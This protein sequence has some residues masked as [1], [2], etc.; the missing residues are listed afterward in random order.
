MSSLARKKNS[1]NASGKSALEL[2]PSHPTRGAARDRHERAVGCGGRGCAFDERHVKR[3]AK[4]CGPDAPMLASSLADCSVRRW[5]QESPVAKE[6]TK[7]TVKPLRREGRIASAEPV[8]SCAH[9]LCILHTRPRVQR[10]PGLPCALRLERA[11]VFWTNS[12]GLRGEIVKLCL[13]YCLRRATLSPVIARLDRAI[14]YSRDD[15]DGIEKPQ[16]TGCPA[17]AGHDSC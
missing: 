2:R 10:A 8:C 4:S 14:Q 7:E 13:V 6:S 15:S 17:F 12:R 11:E 16:R 3:T 1:L 9:F 5:W